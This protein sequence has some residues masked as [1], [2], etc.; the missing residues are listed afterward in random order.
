MKEIV[1]VTAFFDIGRGRFQKENRGNEEYLDYFK[2]WGKF[3]NRLICFTDAHMAS[4]VISFRKSIGLAEKTEAVV[5]DD[6]TS[7]DQSIVDVYKKM[8]DVENSE[9]FKLFRMR[10]DAMENKANYD[11][12]M[13]LKFWCINEAVKRYCLNDCNIVWMDFGFDHGG[14]CYANPDEFS[15]EWKYD[16]EEKIYL[17]HIGKLDEK[18]IFESVRRLSTS[19]MGAMIM[20]PGN[21][22]EWFWQHIYQ[23]M[24]ELTDIGFIDDD[25]LLLLLAYRKAPDRM[26]MIEST[27][28]KPLK[29]C[30]NEHLTIKEYDVVSTNKVKRFVSHSKKAIQ[31]LVQTAKSF[32]MH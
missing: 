1:I 17:W 25:Q 5:I 6:Y 4:E 2:R 29:E 9:F 28:F 26:K 16:F 19:V 22:A 7:V 3:K 21:M 8:R 10:Y 27:W 24:I 23:V 14:E 18:P 32:M 15:F 31:Y 11:L 30:G 12:V 13:F 20:I